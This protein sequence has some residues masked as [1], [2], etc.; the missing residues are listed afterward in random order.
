MIFINSLVYFIVKS[1]TCLTSY[2]GTNHVLYYSVT[3]KPYNRA[4]GHMNALKLLNFSFVDYN[5]HVL[6]NQ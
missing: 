6:F 5:R 2:F 4:C 1:S 3:V